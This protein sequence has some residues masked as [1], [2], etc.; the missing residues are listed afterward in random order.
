MIAIVVLAYNR[1][2]LLR[3]CVER[4]LLRTSDATSEILVWNNAS[5]DGTSAYLASLAGRDPRLRVVEHPRNIGLSGYAHAFP[6]TSAPY[7]VTLDEDVIDAPEGW[8]GILL[9]AFQRLPEVGYLATSQVNDENSQCASI[10]YGKD[11]HLYRPRQV[12]GVEILEGPVGGWCAM[13]S[14]Q[15]HDRVG[16][17]HQDHKQVF[18]HHDALYI[19]AI[20][21]LGYGPAILKDL[22]VFHA[23]GPYYSQTFAEKDAFYAGLRRSQGRKDAVKR[24]LLKVPMAGPLNDRYRW[25]QAPGTTP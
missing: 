3:Q 6:L 15:L 12:N 19:A 25:F 11:W 13:T 20:E 16:G 21:K 14:R 7:L 23:S 17:F 9:D 10:M 4:V 24:L 1:V 2:H 8:D 18:F 22:E 5:S